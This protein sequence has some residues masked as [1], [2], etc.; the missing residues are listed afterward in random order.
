MQRGWVPYLTT[1]STSIAKKSNYTLQAKQDKF[2]VYTNFVPSKLHDFE[3]FNPSATHFE[4]N[5]SI[6]ICKTD[7]E[8]QHL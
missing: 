2:F 1:L 7:S 4:L 5:T 8:L 6:A 3:I